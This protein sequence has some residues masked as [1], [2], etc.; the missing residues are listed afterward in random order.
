MVD[1]NRPEPIKLGAIR[2]E[3]QLLKGAPTIVGKPTWMIF[4]PVQ[5]RYFEIDFETSSDSE[6]S[7]I[8]LKDGVVNKTLV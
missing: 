7:L 5:H 6:I 4:D 2:E 1:E 3:L 8:L